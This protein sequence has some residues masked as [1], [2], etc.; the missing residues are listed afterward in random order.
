MGFISGYLNSQSMTSIRKSRLPRTVWCGALSWTSIKFIW[1]VALAHGKRLRCRTCLYTCWFM[2]PS[3][4]ISSLLPPKWNLAHSMIDGLT[5]SFIPCTQTASAAHPATYA[6]V[7]RNLNTDSSVKIE[8]CQW[9][10]FQTRWRLAHWRQRRWCIKSSLGH[11]ASFREWSPA[12]RRHQMMV[13]TERQYPAWRIF[14]DLKLGLDRNLVA[15]I[16]L[17]KY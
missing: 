2:V 15:C 5:F 3:S 16:I 17:S 11:C 7:W 1:K 13:C 4:T 12:A 9:Q 10:M 8:C 14:W 6:P